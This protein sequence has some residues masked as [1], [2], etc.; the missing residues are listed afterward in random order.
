MGGVAAGDSACLHGDL[1]RHGQRVSIPVDL[2]GEMSFVDGAAHAVDDDTQVL[3][4]MENDEGDTLECV[5]A[6]VTEEEW[7]DEYGDDDIFPAWPGPG[8]F[9][10]PTVNLAPGIVIASTL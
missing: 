9:T 1:R 4:V 7:D 5:A 10:Y 3:L 2:A 8:R 6:E